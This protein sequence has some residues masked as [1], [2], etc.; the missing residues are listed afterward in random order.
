MLGE[1]KL[2]AGAPWDW[3]NLTDDEVLNLHILEG[4]LGSKSPALQYNAAI[5]CRNLQENVEKGDGFDTL[6][7]IRLCAEHGLVIPVW[8]ATAFKS[9]YDPVHN[10][11][12]S[13]WDDAKSFGRPYPAKTNLKAER[14][15]F[16]KAGQI[17]L[18]VSKKIENGNSV[19]DD[20]FEQVGRCFYIEKTAVQ[21]YYRYAK[22]HMGF[23][24]F[25]TI[26]NSNEREIE[27]LYANC[28]LAQWQGDGKLY[29]NSGGS[30]DTGTRLFPR[31]LR[32][33]R[34]VTNS[35]EN[36]SI[37]PLQTKGKLNDISGAKPKSSRKTTKTTRG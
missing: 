30:F 33:R 27:R 10:L 19:G 1:V 16:I 4:N 6:T 13:S 37:K 29:L 32:P 20:L 24:N 26:T 3:I 11:Q 8:L 36:S 17:W 18:A 7:C 5:Q 15:K 14:Q 31:V 28:S 21:K 35:T 2:P 23:A 9:K 34:G 25:V 22:E 12:V